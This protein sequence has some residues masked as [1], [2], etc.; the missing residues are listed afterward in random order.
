M[1]YVLAF[2]DHIT[3]GTVYSMYFFNFLIPLLIR[4]RNDV[5]TFS[6]QDSDARS[7]KKNAQ[8]RLHVA[9]GRP[10]SHSLDPMIWTNH[11]GDGKE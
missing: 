10:N 9:G 11:K 1:L 4:S 3:A 6:T 7:Q 5:V 8:V 2:A